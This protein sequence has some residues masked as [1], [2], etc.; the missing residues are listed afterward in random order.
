M[1][2][3]HSQPAVGQVLPHSRGRLQPSPMVPQYDPPSNT[4]VKVGV[5]LAPPPQ[6][7]GPPAPHT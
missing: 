5:Q 1:F 7:P 6:I 4:Q 3:T 2:S